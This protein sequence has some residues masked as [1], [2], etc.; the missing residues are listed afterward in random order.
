[1]SHPTSVF[2]L[3]SWGPERGIKSPDITG[4]VRSRAS[5]GTQALVPS[6]VERASRQRG[7]LEFQSHIDLSWNASTPSPSL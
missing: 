7:V 1:M 3:R 4:Q 5:S 6:N 2:C